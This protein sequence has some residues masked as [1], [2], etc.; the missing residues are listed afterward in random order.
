LINANWQQTIFELSQQDGAVS[1]DASEQVKKVFNEL[2]TLIVDMNHLYPVIFFVDD[3]QWIDDV[4]ARFLN[5]L[6]KSSNE[7]QEHS[8][9][10]DQHTH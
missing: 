6:I 7:K 8:G 5:F 2:S 4:T 1:A 3:A 9:D 10:Q